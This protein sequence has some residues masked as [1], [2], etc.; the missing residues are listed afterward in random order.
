MVTFSGRRADRRSQILQILTEDSEHVDG[1]QRKIVYYLPAEVTVSGNAA[2]CCA[3]SFCSVY[4]LSSK[5]RV[6]IA[7][8]VLDRA[9][10]VDDEISEMRTAKGEGRRHTTL[11][12]FKAEFSVL[13]DILPTSLYTNKDYH[14]P[15]CVS[16]QTMYIEY[17]VLFHA[18]ALE[19][20]PD[21]RPY[22]WKVWL[23]LWQLKYP[24]VT[25]PKCFAFSVCSTC[26]TLHDR[27]LT[28]TKSK[29]KSKLVQYKEFR[30][31][32][33]NFVSKERL[34]YRENQRL[35]REY[36]DKFVSLCIDGMDQA[37]LRSPHFAGG[38]I[39]KGKSSFNCYIILSFFLN[40]EI[41]VYK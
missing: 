19:Y 31:I 23:S 15:K 40:L 14:L 29:D 16:K 41:I 17:C 32:H 2:R 6:I 36:P 37:K 38:G 9:V 4:G 24:F 11:L 7:N 30:R 1:G 21:H 27:I 3:K 28:S 10:I 35:A 39:P 34:Q 26:A 25:V 12:W 33:L 5:T 13:C 8:M 20:G 22:S 18:N